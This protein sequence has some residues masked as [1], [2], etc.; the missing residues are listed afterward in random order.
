[1]PYEEALAHQELAARLPDNDPR[2]KEH[3]RAAR[4]ICDALDAAMQS[5]A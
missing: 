1:M 3:E 2:R 5:T 4:V